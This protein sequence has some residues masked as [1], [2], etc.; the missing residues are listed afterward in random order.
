MNTEVQ[1][2]KKEAESAYHEIG[3]VFFAYYHKLFQIDK[4]C[5]LTRQEAIKQGLNPDCRGVTVPSTPINEPLKSWMES[6]E[7]GYANLC[8]TEDG[9]LDFAHNYYDYCLGGWYGEQFYHDIVLGETEPILK[10]GNHS[11]Y[12]ICVNLERQR[13]FVKKDKYDILKEHKDTVIKLANELI[14]KQ[15]LHKAYIESVMGEAKLLD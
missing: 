7:Q 14:N 4:V 10:K 2:F 13:W 15:T 11:D 1:E 8:V 9:F 6:V 3:H 12:N 5:I